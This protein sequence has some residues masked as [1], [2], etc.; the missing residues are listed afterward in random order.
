MSK[1]EKKSRNEIEFENALLYQRCVNL[2]AAGQP[3]A[4]LASEFDKIPNKELIQKYLSVNI[5]DCYSMRDA[6]KEALR[7]DYSEK[8]GK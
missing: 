3:F 1:T 8:G 6:I 4:D 2:I 5:D 7:T